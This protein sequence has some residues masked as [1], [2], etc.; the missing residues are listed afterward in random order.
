MLQGNKVRLRATE[1]NDA[2]MLESLWGD[3]ETHLVA[4][5]GPYIPRSVAQR[6]ARLEKN[7]QITDGPPPSDIFL[8]AESLADGKPVGTGSLWGID[9]FNGYAHL[10]IALLPSVRGQ[11]YGTDIIGV[12]CDYGFR[13]NNLRR[14]ELE[15]LGSNA[16]MRRTAEKLGFALEGT[17]REREYIAG[18]YHDLTIYGMLR[19]EWPGLA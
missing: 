5:G 17:Q 7:L 9:R 18:S 11:G 13:L 14:L 3:L 4:D 15:T 12:L 8:L 10:G 16:A 19:T 1:P 6:R 2:E